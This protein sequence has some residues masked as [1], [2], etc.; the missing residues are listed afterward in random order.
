MRLRKDKYDRVNLI[1]PR[2][3][4]CLELLLDEGLLRAGGGGGGGGG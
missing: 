2:V 4:R 3:L 1:E